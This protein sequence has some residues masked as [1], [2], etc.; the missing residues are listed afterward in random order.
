[1]TCPP[2]Q[3]LPVVGLAARIAAGLADGYQV[4][5]LVESAV[6]R[7]RDLVPDDLAARGFDWSNASSEEAKC[8]LF[9]NLPTSPTIPTI[10]AARIDPTPKT[11]GRV[12][13]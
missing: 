6:A 4:H 10:F 5:G 2:P 13:P 3:L 1:V 7:Q 9:G 8:S 12:V 11:S